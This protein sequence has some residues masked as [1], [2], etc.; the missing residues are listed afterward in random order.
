MPTLFCG[1]QS[2][3]AWCQPREPHNCLSIKPSAIVSPSTYI[4]LFLNFSSTTHSF[5]MRSFLCLVPLLLTSIPLVSAVVA[6]QTP[7]VSVDGHNRPLTI[8]STGAPVTTRDLEHTNN[9]TRRHDGWVP[10][11]RKYLGRHC[12]RISGIIRVYKASDQSEIGFVNGALDNFGLL[13]LTTDASQAL[14]V[15]FKVCEK[16]CAV[17]GPLDAKTEVV[18][19]NFFGGVV[20][21]FSTNN[22]LAVGSTNYAYLS[23]VTQNTNPGSPAQPGPNSVSTAIGFPLSSETA[24]WF[25]DLASDALTAQWINMDN[26]EPPT[27]IVYAN[28]DNDFVIT[29]DVA[30]HTARFNGFEVNFVLDLN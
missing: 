19:V 28:Q 4:S 25:L 10:K 27:H 16:Q 2:L 8:L 12:H 30:A 29:G 13:G 11:H 23:G 1:V 5:N 21:A 20:G 3:N 22:D 7:P 17:I 15:S 6:R 9:F 14:E 24:I 26:S 18:G